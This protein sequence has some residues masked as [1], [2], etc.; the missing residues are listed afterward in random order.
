MPVARRSVEPP[1]LV[2]RQA[3]AAAVPLFDLQIWLWGRD[4]LHL[5]GN[6]LVR[7]GFVRHPPPPRIEAT[8]LYRLRLPRGRRVTLR[9]FGLFVSDP[10][11]GGLFLERFVFEPRWTAARDLPD[12]AWHRP[13]LPDLGVPRDE[14]RRRQARRLTEWAVEWMARYEDWA[15]ENLGAAHRRRATAAWRDLGKP[16]V[17]AGTLAEAWRAWRTALR[18][19]LAPR[20]RVQR[21]RAKVRLTHDQ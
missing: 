12:N 10:R 15:W 14:A 20:G 6:G 16:V 13:Q 11:W 5:G 9:G 18:P 19:G 3:Q 7:H 4:V 2:D 1:P 17:P 8:S 21:P